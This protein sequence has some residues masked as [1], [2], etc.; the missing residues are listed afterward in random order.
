MFGFGTSKP[1]N[2]KQEAER[3][4]IERSMHFCKEQ[5]FKMHDCTPDEAERINKQL[6][7]HCGTDK[8]LPFDFKRKVLER[9]RQYECFANMRATDHALHAAL[10]L[11]AGEHMV[12][13]A[14]K[15]GEGRR[16]FS[17]ACGLGADQD[18]RMAAQ[19]LMETI[20]M[21]GGVQHKGPTRAKPAERAP[22][23]PNRAKC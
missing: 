8:K 12:E 22:R 3:L 2:D 16:F 10:R 13:R 20:M 1:S 4:A 15:L 19:R 7:D 17:K 9:A 6:K 14:Q 18:F 21:T 11:A 23:A 5:L